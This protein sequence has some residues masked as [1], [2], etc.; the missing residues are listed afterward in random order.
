[1]SVTDEKIK[2]IESILGGHASNDEVF[3]LVVTDKDPDRFDV[4]LAYFQRSVPWPERIVLPLTEALFIVEKDG[5]G[6]VK[7]RCGH[8]FGDY[9]VNWK[10]GARVSVRRTEEQ[11]REIYPPFTHAE[12]GWQELREFLCPGCTTLLEVEAVAPGYPVT[13]DALPDVQ[14]L[15]T[16]WLGQECPLAPHEFR[17]LTLEHLPERPAPTGS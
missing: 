1:M 10:V 11:F 16:Q 5:G 8:E 17:D 3:R 9:R 2:Q 15:Y 6:V 4:V 14:A 12:P 7:C 13:F